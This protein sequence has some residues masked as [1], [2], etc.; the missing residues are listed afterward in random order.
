MRKPIKPIGAPVLVDDFGN[1]VW[2][3]RYTS[4]L[5]AIGQH[6]YIGSVMPNV[7]DTYVCAPDAA[8]AFQAKKRAFDECEEN[9]NTC[10][11]FERLPHE[12]R[13]DGMLRWKCEKVPEMHPLVYT[14]SGNEFWIHP[15]DPM[16]M[17]CYHARWVNA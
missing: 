6:I 13:F 7:S 11:S 5:V 2:K 16:G 15:D 12:K 17:P 3:C 10:A 14:K 1:E 9:C 4:K 8:K